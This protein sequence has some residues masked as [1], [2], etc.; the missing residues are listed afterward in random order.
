MSPYTFAA[1]SF[2]SSTLPL[3]VGP[4]GSV[5][6]EQVGSLGQSVSVQTKAGH[7]WTHNRVI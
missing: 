4:S 3:A 2:I 6:T 7:Q 5:Q 1:S